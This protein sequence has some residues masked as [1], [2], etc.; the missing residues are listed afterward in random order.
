MSSDIPKQICLWMTIYI[1]IYIY[2]YV[3][4]YIYIAQSA[5][6]EEYTNCFSAEG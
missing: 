6:A 4:V 1:Y 3:Y 2:A 5:E